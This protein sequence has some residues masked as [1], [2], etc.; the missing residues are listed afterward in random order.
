MIRTIAIRRTT[1]I[2]PIKLPI[3]IPE[4]TNET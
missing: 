3:A 4:K 1:R 2:R